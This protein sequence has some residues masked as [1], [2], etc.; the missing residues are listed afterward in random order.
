MTVSVPSNISSISLATD[1]LSSVNEPEIWV[2]NAY[3]L[4]AAFSDE[5]ASLTSWSV[6]NVASKEELKFSWLD[7]LSCN[8][9]DRLVKEP[10]IWSFNA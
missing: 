1:E 6:A 4:V 2:F 8:E 10:D 7:I 5:T 9:L 3:E